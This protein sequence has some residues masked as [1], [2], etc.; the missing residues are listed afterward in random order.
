METGHF[1]T[2]VETLPT[3]DAA[4]FRSA[5]MYSDRLAVSD[6]KSK[7]SYGDLAVA[8]SSVAVF[9]RSQ[10]LALEA[11]V[12]LSLKNC[13]AQLICHFG[14]LAAGGVSVPL[15]SN[16]K[17]NQIAF[18]LE[19]TGAKFLFSDY[20]PENVSDDV[21][22]LLVDEKWIESTVAT[23][24]ISAARQSLLKG[25]ERSQL[26]CL[27][28]TSGSTAKPKAVRLTHGSILNS[29]RNIV[30]YLKYDGTQREA[31]VLPLSHSFGL[32]HVYCLLVTGGYAWIDDGL[33]RP[34]RFL[35]ALRDQNITGFPA[36]PTAMQMLMGPYRSLFVEAAKD[37]KYVVVN[38]A[39]LPPAVTS[40]ILSALPEFN[41][42][43]YYGLTEASRSTFVNLSGEQEDRY[44]SVGPASPNVRLS[45]R[46]ETGDELPVGEEGEIWITGD[47]LA[48]GYWRASQEEEKS[49]RDGWLRTGDLGILDDDG[50]LFLQG[51]VTDT[52]NVDGLKVSPQLVEETLMQHPAVS[53]VAVSGMPDPNG[54]L[55]EVVGALVVLA[56]EV[57]EASLRRYCSTRLEHFMV[58]VCFVPVKAV[59]RADSGKFVRRDIKKLLMQRANER[60]TG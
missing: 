39:P 59:P 14:V 43:V 15:A 22:C 2:E 1:L 45:A 47:H 12:V 38:S 18:Y 23:T 58:P 46:S 26:A 49:F 16:L 28:Y 53:D 13:I 55:N 52:I 10:G 42:H 30:Q 7:I 44:S 9:L 21:T 41:V 8:V 20:V 29:L 17:E 11:P 24:E 57:D 27:M 34:K 36:T 40:E 37:V 60:G 25:R 51:R 6:P 5:E 54:I 35:G 31:V 33:K 48:T 32:G 50:Y 56:E 4:L 19:D 3:I